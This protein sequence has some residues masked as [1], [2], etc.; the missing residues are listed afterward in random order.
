MFP[1]HW[2]W[3][4]A[5]R[6][7]Q[8]PGCS[9]RHSSVE[10][11]IGG[12]TAAHHWELTEQ[13][14]NETLVFTTR[15]V[16]EKRVTAQG[17]AF[18]L[19]SI[20]AKRLFGLENPVARIC[21]GLDIGPGAHACRHDRRARGRR[22]HRSRGRLPELHIFMARPLTANLLIRYAE[23]FNNGVIF[24]RLGF[25]ADTPPARQELSRTSAAPG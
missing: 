18:R 21:E 24:K 8:I 7:S 11:Y 6:L 17:V 13:L 25:L 2:I 3:L 15:R 14:F 9:S 1:C 5:N 22:R 16:I 4:A 12:W 19:R 10:C 20:K 23:Q